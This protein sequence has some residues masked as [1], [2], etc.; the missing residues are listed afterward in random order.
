MSAAKLTRLEHA[1]WRNVWHGRMCCDG[2]TEAGKIATIT[3]CLNALARLRRYGFV[4]RD[5]YNLTLE[6]WQ[7]LVAV[8]P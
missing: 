5:R 1:C 2:R 7:K 4:L 6:G 3:G 8:K